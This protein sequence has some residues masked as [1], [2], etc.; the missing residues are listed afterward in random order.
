MQE[1]FA[2]NEKAFGFQVLNED[3]D[4]SRRW[5]SRLH[6]HSQMRWDLRIVQTELYSPFASLWYEQLPD[7]AF[8]RHRNMA[9]APS[10]GSDWM[11]QHSLLPA[12]ASV[13]FPQTCSR[14]TESKRSYAAVPRKAVANYLVLFPPCT[15]TSLYIVPEHP[16][17]KSS[18]DSACDTDNPYILDQGRASAEMAD[19][20]T[21]LAAQTIAV[22][23]ED[24]SEQHSDVPSRS[25]VHSDGDHE[26][27]IEKTGN[28]TV[29][30]N[31]CDPNA[32]SVKDVRTAQ[33]SLENELRQHKSTIK[34]LS[35]ERDKLEKDSNRNYRLLEAM[36]KSND[37]LE[38][39]VRDL[40]L[41]LTE[42]SSRLKQQVIT[43]ANEK[44]AHES[45]I[46]EAYRRGQL[47]GV[48]TQLATNEKVVLI[49]QVEAYKSEAS[50]WKQEALGRGSEMFNT[51][52]QASVD[53][54]VRRKR[55]PDSMAIEA[56]REELEALKAEK[57]KR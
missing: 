3:R 43:L 53:E 37:N 31:D 52:W 49:Q 45:E 20:A 39:Q 1:I 9:K 55:E 25:L 14:P 18:N 42:D 47:D 21:P 17:P 7:F 29:T 30:D 6:L 16:D 23:P 38:R 33:S 22:A 40:S 35:L 46:S 27:E 12:F 48:R 19:H 51:C 41:Q 15:K 36:R 4:C 34:K 54:A 10:T 5:L 56:L 57:R 44:R 2:S 8:D 28:G 11:V 13:C 50:K 26:K 32:P 24:L